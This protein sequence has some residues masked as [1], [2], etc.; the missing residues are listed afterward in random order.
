MA[1]SQSCEACSIARSLE[2]VITPHESAGHKRSKPP[3]EL[4]NVEHPQLRQP[5]AASVAAKEDDLVIAHSAGSQAR[6][7]A[8]TV[9]GRG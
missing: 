1:L 9:L 6:P 2:W 5:L 8:H 7:A 4:T 3:Y